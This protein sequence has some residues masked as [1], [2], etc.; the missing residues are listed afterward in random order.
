M[1]TVSNIHSRISYVVGLLRR[2][3]R[4]DSAEC[5]GVNGLLVQLLPLANVLFDTKMARKVGGGKL[6]FYG[7]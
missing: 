1:V 2:V 5:L 6:L 4:V 3:I 7:L